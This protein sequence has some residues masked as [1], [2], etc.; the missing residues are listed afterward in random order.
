MGSLKGKR[1]LVTAGAQGIGKAVSELLLAQGCDVAVH[2]L[3]SRDGAE[4]LMKHA[5]R[6]GGRIEAVQGD[7]TV[8]ADCIR[9]VRESADYFGGLDILV[10]NAGSLVA[11][12]QLIE[13]DPGYID[14]V[15]AVNLKS[16]ILV[17][18]EAVPHLQRNE[19]SSIVNIA[20]LAG[21]KGGHSGSMA[22]AASKGGVLAWTRGLAD[23]LG[24][25][26]IRINAV[27]PGLI[28]GSQFHTVHTTDESK[29]KTIASLPVGRAGT[30][31]DV[32][33]AV[34]FLAS[35]Y[36]GFIHGATLDINGG[37]YYC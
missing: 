32:A 9:V 1:A 7:L 36:D 28:L 13:M 5:I 33:R 21:R 10:N 15:L 17:T 2:Y 35:E 25:T 30:C 14:Q 29:Q 24:R 20:S 3:T 23:E 34:V 16:M 31:E 27:A 19:H 8:E 4:E 6:Q 26:G 37:A 18:R 12:K 22:Y 11:R